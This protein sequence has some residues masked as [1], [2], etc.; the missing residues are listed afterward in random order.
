MQSDLFYYQGRQAAELAAAGAA[1][2]SRVS[3]IHRELARRYGERIKSL[4]GDPDIEI[5][6]VTA[7]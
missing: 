6:L 4:D 3:E 1:E 5:H 2:D 7:A